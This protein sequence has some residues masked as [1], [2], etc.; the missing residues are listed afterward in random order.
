MAGS[1]GEAQVPLWLSE[2]GFI[3]QTSHVSL[4]GGGKSEPCLAK[5]DGW[6]WMSTYSANGRRWSPKSVGQSLRNCF[7]ALVFSR[8]LFP[9]FPLPLGA[10]PM[11]DTLMGLPWSI[12]PKGIL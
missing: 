6:T 11:P 12:V 5:H 9:L 8:T 2:K 7:L 3:L 4:A 1:P 10:Q